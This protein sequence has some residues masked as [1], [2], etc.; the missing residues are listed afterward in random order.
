M[1][2]KTQKGRKIKK[3]KQK[4][5]S[6]GKTS[7]TSRSSTDDSNSFLS[8]MCRWF[9]DHMTLLEEHFRLCDPHRRG[10]VSLQEFHYALV[11]L[12]VPCQHS[13]L[14]MLTQHLKNDNDF[15]SYKDLSRRVDNLRLKEKLTNKHSEESRINDYNDHQVL[16]PGGDLK[17]ARLSVRLIPF[18][19]TADHPGNFELVLLTSCRVSSLIRM[20]QDRVGVQTF[21][22]EVFRSRVPSE[23]A[24]LPPH[25]SLQE[26][27]FSGGVEEA[28][29]EYT[30]YYDYNLPLTDCPILNCD[31]YFRL[32]A[33]TA[34]SRGSWSPVV[35][36]P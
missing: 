35:I 1:K 5:V 14:H 2:K 22:L 10:T 20:I 11:N 17:F 27:G 3:R 6:A 19:L 15:V 4:K 7:Q 30:V 34:T 23:E 28:P 21:L 9:S 12:N 13:E 18:D 16:N 33:E 36:N 25:S 29:P 31:Y 24:R 32:G 8:Q 26:C